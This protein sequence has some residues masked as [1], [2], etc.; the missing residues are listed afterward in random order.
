MCPPYNTFDNSFLCLLFKSLA[1][2]PFNVFITTGIES[3]GD[4]PINK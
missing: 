2:T 3:C 1:E 4:N